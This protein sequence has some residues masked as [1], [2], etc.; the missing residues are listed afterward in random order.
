MEMEVGFR[1]SFEE[2]SGKFLKGLLRC[3]DGVFSH[4]ISCGRRMPGIELF[5]NRWVVFRRFAEVESSIDAAE[6]VSC[7]AV[8]RNAVPAIDGTRINC[9]LPS[10]RRCRE[11]SEFAALVQSSQNNDAT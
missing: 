5:G 9:G 10:S 7:F 4:K 8:G 2:D 11:I 6:V 3:R 1:E